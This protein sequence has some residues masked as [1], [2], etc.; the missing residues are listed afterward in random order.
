MTR[1]FSIPFALLTTRT[2]ARFALLAVIGV[3][4]RSFPGVL[5]SSATLL[6]VVVSY[7][8]GSARK[9][10][11]HTSDFPKRYR[12]C[13][14]STSRAHFA[15]RR[16]TPQSLIVQCPVLNFSPLQP[17]RL[18][19]PGGEDLLASTFCGWF[20]MIACLRAGDVVGFEF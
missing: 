8:L 13:A 1:R 9:R 2:S 14:R 19:Q 3:L 16:R 11:T 18:S 5:K 4:P 6:L 12:P 7:C 20:Q 10:S 17:R 15:P